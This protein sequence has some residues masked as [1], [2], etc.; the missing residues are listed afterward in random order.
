MQVWLTSKQVVSYNGP[1][2]C[3][4]TACLSLTWQL[5]GRGPWSLL[6]HPV[7]QVGEKALAKRR[8]GEAGSRDGKAA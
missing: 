4:D 6:L 2:T 3:V 1:G 5:H 8:A 7:M